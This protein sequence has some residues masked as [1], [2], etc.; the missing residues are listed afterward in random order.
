MIMITITITFTITITQPSGYDLQLETALCYQHF[1]CNTE[2]RT[3]TEQ[4][5]RTSDSDTIEHVCI[6]YIY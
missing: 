6:I 1:L 5:K 3:T 4:N 2:L